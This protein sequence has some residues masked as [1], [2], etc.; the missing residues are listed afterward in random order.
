M[1]IWYEA[2]VRFNLTI[3]RS[4]WQGSKFADSV[5]QKF[6]RDLGCTNLNDIR[7]LKAS[8]QRMTLGF[9]SNASKIAGLRD[10]FLSVDIRHYHIKYLY[11]EMTCG[12][13]QRIIR[14][15][16]SSDE[17]LCLRW[18][19]SYRLSKWSLWNEISNRWS[20]SYLRQAFDDKA[21][22]AKE[23][24]MQ[25]ELNS[26]N[27]SLPMVTIKHP[28]LLNAS[29]NY[30]VWKQSSWGLKC[31]GACHHESFVY[32]SENNIRYQ[33]RQLQVSH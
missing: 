32:S 16:C 19:S 4:I 1:I 31:S 7:Q 20:R 28:V 25:C 6:K 8:I 24:Q 14:K 29:S 22:S 33:L 21:L 15:G 11:Y 30:M 9:K 27:W 26:Q 13:L 5:P 10:L 17:K 2:T 18:S 3:S 12:E 23:L